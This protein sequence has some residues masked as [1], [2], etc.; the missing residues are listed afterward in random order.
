[1]GCTSSVPVPVETKALAKP[2]KK[3]VPAVVIVPNNFNGKYQIGEVLGKK[4]I[5]P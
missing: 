4:S 2:E 1:M 5:S 3:E